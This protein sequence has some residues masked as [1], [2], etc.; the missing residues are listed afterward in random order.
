MGKVH[1]PAL[2]FYSEIGVSANKMA[3]IIVGG[4][5]TQAGGPLPEATSKKLK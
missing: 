3:G 5:K 4:K 1:W 2:G